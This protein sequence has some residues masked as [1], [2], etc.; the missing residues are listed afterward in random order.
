MLHSTPTDGE[1]RE[2][3]QFL[4]N[5]CIWYAAGRM[6]AIC[7]PSTI[8]KGDEVMLGTQATDTSVPPHLQ[9]GKVVV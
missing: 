7:P 5:G 2:W 4:C 6:D 8:S 9:M 1:S 3:M